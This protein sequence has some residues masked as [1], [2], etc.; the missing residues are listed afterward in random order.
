M[1]LFRKH[2][3]RW[4][5]DSG[6]IARRYLRG[7]FAVDLLTAIPFETVPGLS[8]IRLVKLIR[9]IRLSAREDAIQSGPTVSNPHH[10]APAPRPPRA[11][12][13][14]R[15]GLDGH[16]RD[17]RAIRRVTRQDG[18]VPRATPRGPPMNGGSLSAGGGRVLYDV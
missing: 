10:A 16:D 12:A 9:L 4:V 14:L 2:G 5:Y 15:D 3:G 18:D 11:A 13:S 8:L 1:N 17:G 7:Y 6:A